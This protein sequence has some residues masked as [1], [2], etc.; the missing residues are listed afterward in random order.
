[1]INESLID[2]CVRGYGL[3]ESCVRHKVEAKKGDEL[4]RLLASRFGGIPDSK[5]M[6]DFWRLPGDDPV[7]V[8]YACGDGVSTL[9]LWQSQQPLLDE[10]ELRVPW[11]LE[12]D[13]LPY[14]AR[15]HLR[16]MK[17]D[18]V[19]GD[20]LM[21]DG[22]IFDLAIKE[23]AAKFPPGFNVNSPTEVELLYRSNGYK[24]E[25][26]D[27][28]AAG[29]P[30]FTEK[31]LSTN[32]IG[33]AIM[34]VRKLR[35]AKDSF[36]TPLL[37]TNNIQGRVHAVLNQS[38]SDDYGVIGARFSCSGP[39]MQA[40][41]KRNKPIGKLV[42]RL[43][44]AD[45]GMEIEEADAKQQEPRLFAYF[46][47][48]ERLCAGYRSATLD[49]HDLTSEGLGLPRDISKRLGLGMLTGMQPRALA[50]H[51]RWT[52]PEAEKYHA[53]FFDVFSSIQEFQIGAKTRWKQL[54]FVRS[55]LGRKARLDD[56]RFAYRATSRIIQNS[57]GDH[58]KLCL[59]RAC[60]YEDA[61]PDK[62]Q[63]LMT[64]HDSIIWQKDPGHD[65]SEL[66]KLLEEVPFS[67]EFHLDGIPIPFEIGT[68]QDWAAASYGK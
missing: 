10:E 35:K 13:L 66:I 24:D 20:E 2:D 8:D 57:G 56:P 65:R 23:A 45:D 37:E 7:V 27:R 18:H 59:L 3:A 48:D 25:Q 42:R 19:Y 58:M 11:Q 46:S 9:A 60:Q 31:W 17:I 38:K 68:G 16:G 47:D 63:L 30:S 44:V 32:E 29:K 5:A 49:I 26:F 40:V 50:G 33:D 21:R 22:G 6:K 62:L 39:N 28:T 36:A 1:M 43:V 15:L 14:V 51:M 4:Y 53:G 61:Y 12:C 55:R 64:I 52:L 54:G 67:P 41:T 34:A